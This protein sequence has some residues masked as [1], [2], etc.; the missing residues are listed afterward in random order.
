[1]YTFIY[2]RLLRNLGIEFRG[3]NL[4]YQPYRRF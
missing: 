2:L 3:E 1:M 4:S